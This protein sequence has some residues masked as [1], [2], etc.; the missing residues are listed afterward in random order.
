MTIIDNVLEHHGIKGMKWGVRRSSGGGSTSTKR[1]SPTSE[2]F[3]K[4]QA[5][6]SKV[7]RGKTHALT[8]DELQAL[9]KR[10]NLEK[11]F[12][13]LSSKTGDK[14]AAKAGASWVAKFLGS[15]AEGIAKQQVIRLGN[16][17]VTKQINDMLKT[18]K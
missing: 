4:A 12:K 17:V 8:N 18:K 10:M 14:N 5:A 9:N 1:R 7:K 11:Q 3:K 15:S 2:D 16:E 13:E 6:R